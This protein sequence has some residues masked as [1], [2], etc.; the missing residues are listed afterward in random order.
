MLEF[1]QSIDELLCASGKSVELPDN[2]SIYFAG[3][4]KLPELIKLMPVIRS[5][6]GSI[7]ESASNFEIPGFCIF[8]KLTKLDIRILVLKRGYSGMECPRT[9]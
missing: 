9:Y 6:T 8:P 4:N 7:C 5:S 2:N 1:L 3:T